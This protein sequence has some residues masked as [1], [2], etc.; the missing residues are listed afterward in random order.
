MTTLVVSGFDVIVAGSVT[1]DELGILV[2][3][4]N[5]GDVDPGTAPAPA[6]PGATEEAE[7]ASEDSETEGKT[8]LK[9]E[10]SEL[11]PAT[12]AVLGVLAEFWNDED[13]DPGK[14]PAP[15]PPDP[16][17]EAED[18]VRDPEIEGET[19]LKTDGI[20]LED[21]EPGKAP[22]PAPPDPIEEAEDAAENPET[23]GETV[24]K[25]DEIELGSVMIV[26][27]ETGELAADDDCSR[28]TVEK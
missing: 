15:A 2:E 12:L 17:E 14:A 23:E 9:I 1:V 21:M 3:L 28:L 24:S 13:V 6:P 4:C 11:G 16:I 22:A 26:E 8:V 7:D 5:N 20:E 19:V 10:E 27:L 18:G 25:I